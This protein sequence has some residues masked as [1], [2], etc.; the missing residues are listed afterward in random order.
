[1]RWCGIRHKRAE[2]IRQRRSFFRY[3]VQFLPMLLPFLSLLSRLSP[4]SRAAAA[5]VAAAISFLPRRLRPPSSS[6]PTSFG[7][8]FSDI[9]LSVWHQKKGVG[10][11]V[12]RGGRRR[13]KGGEITLRDDATQR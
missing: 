11:R 7:D 2:E 5:A 9:S 4:F 10:R 12:E 1:M 3:V 13:E 6:S 8:P